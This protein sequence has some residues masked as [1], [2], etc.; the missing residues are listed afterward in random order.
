MPIWRKLLMHEARFALAF[1]PD[2]AGSNSPAR[3]AMM[4]MT[5]SSS[6]RVKPDCGRR[7]FR[8]NPDLVPSR[9][10]LRTRLPGDCL[11]SFIVHYGTRSRKK[12]CEALGS[13]PFVTLKLPLLSNVLVSTGVQV[14]KGSAMSEDVN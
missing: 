2:N 13:T 6:I 5:T 12:R 8:P 4:A 14:V 9:P 10:F 3:M 11:L 7:A 1:A